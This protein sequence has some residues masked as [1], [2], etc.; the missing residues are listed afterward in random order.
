[1]ELTSGA[2][3]DTAPLLS[4]ALADS[5]SRIVDLCSGAGGPWPDL[6]TRLVQ[7]R[8]RAIQVVL[9]DKFPLASDR[10]DD[11]APRG[12]LLSFHSASVD[13]MHVPQQLTGFRTLFSSFHHFR[14]ADARLILKS[15]VERGEGIAVFE[16]TRR[17]VPL[18]MLAVLIPFVVL[19]G[20]PFVRPFGW[21]RLFW[22]YLVP[23]VPLIALFDGV[24]SCLRTY[25]PAELVE[26]V[27][28]LGGES[29]EWKT[30]IVKSRGAPFGVT[31]LIGRLGG[32]G[33]KR[34]KGEEGATGPTPSHRLQ[35]RQGWQ[36]WQE[37]HA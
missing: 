25:T 22:T 10:T 15:A 23:L 24:V 6:V 4:G 36:G 11:D 30:G 26:L 19:F 29:Y 7:T 37:R 16:A 31:Y 12:R 21:S 2:Y 1:M 35:G 33:G 28:D 3:A 34:G 8:G 5:E 14:P 32:E 27:E 18:I 9:T 20:S 17:H 13:A